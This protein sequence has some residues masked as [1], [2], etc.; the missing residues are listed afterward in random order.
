[1][2]GDAMRREIYHVKKSEAKGKN[3]EW[4]AQ[5]LGLWGSTKDSIPKSILERMTPVSNIH[6][7]THVDAHTHTHRHVH[8]YIYTQKY[9][10]MDPKKGFIKKSHMKFRILSIQGCSM[11]YSRV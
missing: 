11:S 9:T 2:R 8:I 7:Y 5:R 6:T 1:M 4:K 10:H 3:G